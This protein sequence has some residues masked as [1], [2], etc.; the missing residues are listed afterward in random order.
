MNNFCWD[1][2]LIMKKKIYIYK[3]FQLGNI[4]SHQIEKI[5]N[6]P[7]EGFEDNS[8]AI[9]YLEKLLENNKM[10]GWECKYTILEVYE[11]K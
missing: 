9:I 7:K 5:H 3:L 8:Q 6:Q 11:R 10:D 2:F 4:D 1:N